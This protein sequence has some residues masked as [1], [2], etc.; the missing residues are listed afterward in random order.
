MTSAEGVHSITFKDG[1]NHFM[2]E[3]QEPSK[4]YRAFKLS[5]QGYK[6]QE[7]VLL[8]VCGCTQGSQQNEGP[9]EERSPDSPASTLNPGNQESSSSA[10]FTAIP[11]SEGDRIVPALA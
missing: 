3:M 6:F 2:G 5:R 4:Y 11:L 10:N 8:D 9:G 7:G 1:L